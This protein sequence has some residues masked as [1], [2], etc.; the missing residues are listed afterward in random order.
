VRVR[1][2]VRQTCEIFESQILPGVVSKD[3]VHTLVS[4]PPTRAP[5]ESRRRITGRTSSKLCE[6]FP[7]LKKR[8]WGRHFWGR[9]S[10]GATVGQRTAEMIPESLAPHCEPD[11]AANF[12]TES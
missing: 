3:Q 9:R 2:L 7:M 11:R 8:S 12:R 4:A 5:S 1:E 10:F 6:E